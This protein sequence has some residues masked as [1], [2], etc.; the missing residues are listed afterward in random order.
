MTR[1]RNGGETAK[2]LSPCANE[3]AGF[4]SF[5]D[6]NAPELVSVANA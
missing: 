3:V 1:R 6:L 4:S 5:D 2:L